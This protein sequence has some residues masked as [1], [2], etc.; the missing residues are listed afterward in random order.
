VFLSSMYFPSN[1][2]HSSSDGKYK[3]IEVNFWGKQLDARRSAIVMDLWRTTVGDARMKMSI[4]QGYGIEINILWRLG[5]MNCI[6]H[7]MEAQYNES[8]FVVNCWGKVVFIGDFFWKHGFSW[9]NRV[10]C[11]LGIGWM[12][13]WSF[14]ER[15]SRVAE[16]LAWIFS[17]TI[18]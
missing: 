16:K 6:I 3:T 12:H 1:S 15:F 13:F 2:P 4:F 18:D 8:S 7:V 17:S 5:V 9:Q 11:R 14:V 10:W